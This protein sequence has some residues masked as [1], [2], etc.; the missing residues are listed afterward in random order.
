MKK[1]KFILFFTVVL[2][3]LSLTACKSSSDDEE[4]TTPSVE[5]E[6]CFESTD[7]LVSNGGS[8]AVLA[9]AADGTFKRVVFSLNIAAGEAIM[10]LEYIDATGEVAVVIDGQDRVMAI[11]PDDCST[12]N[13]IVDVNLT[14]TV[15]SVTQLS[16]GDYLVTETNNVERFDSSGIRITSGGWPIALQTTGSGVHAL[17]AGGFVHCSTGADVVRT[18]NNAGTQQAT[19][20]SGIAATTDASDCKELADGNI[21]TAW[22]GTT[23]SVIIYNS[24][25]STAL[26][27]YSDL[28]ILSTPGGIAQKANGNILIT[29]RVLNYI[30]EITS[31]GTYVGRIGLGSGLLNTPEYV[32]VYP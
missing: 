27:T 12:R 17:A 22:S 13:L 19:R 29:D 3:S 26:F 28:A 8:D 4:A 14:G 30:V 2:V 21:V 11:D 31:T 20:A 15:R 32:L 25:L 18:Y 9:F 7:I 5:A 16:T 6:A 23:D 1:T 24:N 10:G